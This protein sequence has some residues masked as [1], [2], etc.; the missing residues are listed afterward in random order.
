MGSGRSGCRI[1]CLAL[2][3]G[4]VSSVFFLAACQPSSPGGVTPLSP[5]EAPVRLYPGTTSG[6]DV[7]SVRRDVPP[8]EVAKA[9]EIFRINRKKPKGPYQAVGADLNGDGVAEVLVLF[10]G[11]AWCAKTGC[12]LAILSRHAY[13]YRAMTTIQR[14]K[15]PVRVGRERTNGWR[16]LIVRTGLPGREQTV[17]LKF[18]P[19]G[20]P[21]NAILLSG[22]PEDSVLAAEVLLSSA[23]TISSPR[24]LRGVD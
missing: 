19:N 12:T 6:T 24:A 17:V 20:Y 22:V 3:L 10:A 15:P 8:D 16:D 13:G 18:G 4:V 9:V 1:R 7:P 23:K 21:G 2:G 14:V 11:E 5:P